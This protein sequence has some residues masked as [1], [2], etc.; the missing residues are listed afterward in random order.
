MTVSEANGVP[1]AQLQDIRHRNDQ[2]VDDR[3][4]RLKEGP[5]IELKAGMLRTVL[6]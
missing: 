3:S 2:Y 6:A 4:H 1:A 5:S